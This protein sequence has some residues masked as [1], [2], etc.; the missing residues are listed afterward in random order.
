MVYTGS[1]NSSNL[2]SNSET[3]YRNKCCHVPSNSPKLQCIFKL[4][5]L[6]GKVQQ[7]ST[8]DRLSANFSVSQNWLSHQKLLMATAVS[9]VTSPEWATYVQHMAKKATLPSPTNWCSSEDLERSGKLMLYTQLSK[10]RKNTLKR[11]SISLSA[12]YLSQKLLY[13]RVYKFS[14]LMQNLS[15]SLAKVLRERKTKQ[16]CATY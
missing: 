6:T 16:L 2:V 10:S 9:G 14:A 11:W 8:T 3:K 7:S 13:W 12:V 1:N 5:K 4:L 15:A